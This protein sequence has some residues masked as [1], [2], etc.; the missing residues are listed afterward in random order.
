MCGIAGVISLRGTVERRVLEEMVARI[1]HRGPDGTGVCIVPPVGL[2]HARLSVIDLSGGAQPMSSPDRRLWITFNGEIFNYLELRDDLTRRGHPFATR[3]D[4]EVILHAYEEYGDDCIRLFNGQWA[5]ALWD[6]RAQR[7]LLSRDRLGVRPLFYS[8][9]DDGLV[10]AS[11]VKALFAWHQIS[12]EIDP[13]GLDQTFTFLNILP[14]RTIFKAVSELLP[15]HS[16]SFDSG[17]LRVTRHWEPIFSAAAVGVEPTTRHEADYADELVALLSDA[18]RLRLRSDVP[19]GTYLS[20]G[21]D[22]T[23]ITALARRITNGPVQ[24][25]SVAFEDGDF[26][27]SMYQQ[28]VASFLG[29]AHHTVRCSYEDIARAFPRAVWHSEKP[30]L[31]TAPAPLF[32]LSAL[33]HAHGLKVVLTGEGADEFFGGYDIFKEA[34]LR[35]FCA[36]QPDSRVRPPLLARAYPYLGAYQTRSSAF[37]TAL[38]RMRPTDLGDPFFSHLPRLGILSPMKRVLFSDSLKAAVGQYDAVADLHNS[39]S[40]FYG[41]WDWL[42]R[43]QYLEVLNNLSGYLLS[44]QGDR[45]AMAHGVEGRFPFLDHRVVEFAMRLPARL[46]L[47][48]LNEKIL[49]KRATRDLVPSSITRRRKQPYRAPLARTF[50]QNGSPRRSCEYVAELVSAARVTEAGLFSAKTVAGLMDKVRK[51]QAL[52]IRDN[53]ALVAIVSTQLLVHQFVKGY[54]VETSHAAA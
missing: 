14:P 28:Q 54:G 7:L 27:E 8:M 1:V 41:S 23:V 19:V 9:V 26:D 12:R 2:A 11:E 47:S 18:T 25:F 32:L 30:L 51:G 5:F 3:S 42:S 24:T 31:W 29:T 10:F 49:L 46:K 20:G 48:A 21:L 40:P 36:A 53:W 35:R 34:K 38:C 45:M 6:A 44:S 50:F 17:G 22:S 37:L 13:I 4:T 52:G 16:L 33:V 39:L 15:A 43:A